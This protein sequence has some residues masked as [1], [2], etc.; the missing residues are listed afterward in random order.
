MATPL[1][2]LSR[3]CF[4]GSI[5]T[6]YTEWM[7]QVT[8]VV[9]RNQPK[10]S[11][12]DVD[13]KRNELRMKL[14]AEIEV[15]LSEADRFAGEEVFVTF[16]EKGAS[17]LVGIIETSQEKLVLKI[18]LN[19]IRGE[20]E[21]LEV[22]EREGVTVPHVIEKGE[23]ESK[24]YLLMEHIDAP[25]IHGTYRK[26]EV[27]RKGFYL[28]MGKILRVMHRARAEGYGRF[29]GGKAE[30]SD[31]A[32]WLEETRLQYAPYT[33]E[34][35]LLDDDVH[36][37]VAGAF[38]RIRTFVHNDPQ[39]RYC[40]NDFTYANIFDTSPLTVFDPDPIFSHPYM[41]VARA[42]VQGIGGTGRPE[43]A[44]QLLQGYFGDE[45]IDRG[46]LQAA[47]VVQSCTKFPYWHKTKRVQS[48][49]DVQRYLASTKH[50]LAA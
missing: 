21:F 26:G 39:S 40:H 10:L 2:A 9:F 6:C 27:I 43:A 23:L 24:P 31:F 3:I 28:E 14:V 46:A 22:W 18:P 25:T 38:E 33:A 7:K 17:S 37:S 12:Y 13:R 50:F 36:G 30:H 32:P 8:R 49:Q 45:S 20:A 41:E 42:M 34:Y 4:G 47:L 5:E 16:P 1:E 44:E 29:F 19:S 35:K 15:L 11:E 48:I